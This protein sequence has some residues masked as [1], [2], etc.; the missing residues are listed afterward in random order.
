MARSQ[1][2]INP[3]GG[4][5][6]PVLKGQG[7]LPAALVSSVCKLIVSQESDLKASRY[8][9]LFAQAHVYKH[10]SKCTRDQNPETNVHEE[11]KLYHR[12]QP[13]TLLLVGKYVCL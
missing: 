4:Q 3:K 9:N 13:T 5:Q 11:R 2:K 1:A 10:C 8:K 7:G 6:Q 12:L